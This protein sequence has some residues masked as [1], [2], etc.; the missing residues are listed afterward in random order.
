MPTRMGPACSSW[1]G[2]RNPLL[3]WCILSA[4]STPTAWPCAAQVHLR[5]SL[6]RRLRLPR[7]VRRH[8]RG[9]VQIHLHPW[10]GLQHCSYQLRLPGGQHV[11]RRQV[12]G[13]GSAPCA[14]LSINY[15]TLR[16]FWE[17]GE[18][19]CRGLGLRIMYG[20][21]RAP[22]NIPNFS[23]SGLHSRRLHC[24]PLSMHCARHACCC[25]LCARRVRPAPPPVHAPPQRASAREA[26]VK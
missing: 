12:Q 9:R 10:R 26:Y 18:A 11:Q 1:H 6:R 5:C 23:V 7:D 24:I 15:I 17:H 16:K 8:W 25:R 3:N 21:T 19:G 2:M 22:A 14:C 4:R 20:G 13:N